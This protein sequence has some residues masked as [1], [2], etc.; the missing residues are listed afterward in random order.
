MTSA[1]AATKEDYRNCA[2]D[3]F[4]IQVERAP[5]L[6]GMRRVT[7]AGSIKLEYLGRMIAQGRTQEELASLI[8]NRGVKRNTEKII[9]ATNR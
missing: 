4:E 9:S 2:G 5:E 8:A 3:V 1:I 6:S 7:A